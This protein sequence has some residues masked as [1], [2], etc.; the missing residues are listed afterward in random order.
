MAQRLVSEEWSLRLAVVWL[1]GCAVLY[2]QRSA[3]PEL[4][5][6]VLMAIALS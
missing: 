4:R 3:L 1:H 5:M 2:R 6:A